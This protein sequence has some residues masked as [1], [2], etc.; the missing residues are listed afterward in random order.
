MHTNVA[1]SA[2]QDAEL[3]ILRLHT[4]MAGLRVALDQANARANNA[5]ALSNALQDRLAAAT[6][7][8]TGALRLNDAAEALRRSIQDMRAIGVEVPESGSLVGYFVNRLRAVETET[9]DPRPLTRFVAYLSEHC[10]GRTV[11]EEALV[12]WLADVLE[13][14]PREVHANLNAS[15]G[16]AASAPQQVKPGAAERVSIG[17]FGTKYPDK[18][19]FPVS[20]NRVEEFK[21]AGYVVGQAFLEPA[22]SGQR[23][24]A[25]T[26]PD[27]ETVRDGIAVFLSGVTGK[28]SRTWHPVLDQLFASGELGKWR[29]LLDATSGARANV[30][31]DAERYCKLRRWMSSNVAEGWREVENLA[32]IACYVDWEHFDKALDALPECNVGLCAVS[33]QQEASK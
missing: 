23:A 18:H 9:V 29:A 17:W 31:T 19:W 32:A 6:S 8:K 24:G 26:A 25:A 11:T 28:Q 1:G 4:E 15:R 20:E 14:T 13:S 21:E 27:W 10:S 3:Q 33:V 30:A 5:V 12:E 2:G 7:L 16:L 22:Q